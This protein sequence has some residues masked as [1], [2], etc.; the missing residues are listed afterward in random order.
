MALVPLEAMA[1]GRPVV[2]FDVGGVRQ[3]V[4]DAGAVVAAGDTTALAMAVSRR[5]SDPARATAEGRRGRQRAEL[6]FDRSRM[7]DQIATLVD[8]LVRGRIS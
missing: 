3:S 7:A 8:K 6:L 4:G 2:A 5:L 1:S